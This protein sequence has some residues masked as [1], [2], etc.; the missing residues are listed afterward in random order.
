[1]NLPNHMSLALLAGALLPLAACGDA[2][3]VNERPGIGANDQVDRFDLEEPGFG[4]E[5]VANNIEDVQHPE[6][7]TL[8]EQRGEEQV[9]ENALAF[10]T[11]GTR[12]ILEREGP[13]EA[14]AGSTYRYQLVVRNTSENPVH[15]VKVVE[16]LPPEI[17]FDSAKP[18]PS[19][20]SSMKAQGAPQSGSAEQMARAGQRGQQ[21]DEGPQ[22]AAPAG[23]TQAPEASGDRQQPDRGSSGQGQ[24]QTDTKLTW[25]LGMLGPNE[26][27]TIEITGVVQEEG[28]FDTCSYV[29]A[30][31][32]LCT[33]IAAVAPELQ[34]Q[35]VVV[36]DQRQPV[37]RLYA[38]DDVA[39]MY[40]LLNTGTGATQSATIEEDL[41]DWIRTADG[42][43]RV[44]IEAG[45]I[46]PGEA[47]EQIVALDVTQA[48]EFAGA[49]TA[50]SGE[51]EARS[52]RSTVEILQPELEL[53]VSGSEQAYTDRPTRLRIQVSNPSEDPAVDTVVAIQPPEGA[54]QLYVD[55]PGQMEGNSIL[56]GR[57]DGGQSVTVDASFVVPQPG[58]AETAVVAQ[59]YCVEEQR[60]TVTTNIE[61]ITATQ[62]VV[63]DRQD[64][65][66]TGEETSYEIKVWNEG[67]AP[68]E[69]L[70]LEGQLP[71]QLSFVS[72]GGQS[73]VTGDGKTLTF[74]PVKTLEP[75]AVANWHVR[76]RG[77]S[78]GRGNFEVHMQTKNG[79]K[80]VVSMEPTTVR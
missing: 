13:G 77:E 7:R 8:S 29:E 56:I 23:E 70:R 25:S 9:G 69:D 54:Q 75:G 19:D 3:D 47:F 6:R 68:L 2:A 67:T 33:T 48:G 39:V 40:R 72:G 36:D 71:E 5:T 44:S 49:A 11:A 58:R 34:L 35:R 62:V 24:A 37:Q 10:G 60:K 43:Q 66:P 50:T 20:R 57:I 79:E 46:P 41:P 55:G 74:A 1:M 21:Q 45:E 52:R 18:S 59:A 38:C 15:D 28:S 4:N 42:E 17:S 30:Q 14:R 12:V 80:Q 61:G 63:F 32:T 53:Q 78:S 22:P 64:P 16:I 27:R 51:L 73:E 26:S 31:P 76:V 65:L